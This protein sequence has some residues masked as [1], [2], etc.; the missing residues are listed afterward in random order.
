MNLRRVEWSVE[1]RERS[2]KNSIVKTVIVAVAC[3]LVS[4]LGHAQVTVKV[5]NVECLPIGENAVVWAEVD[6]NLPDSTVHL[7]FRRLHDMVEDFYYVQMV[8]AGQGRY[9][10]VMP[11]AEDRTLDRHE[12]EEE[13]DA[14]WAAWW[15][16]KEVRDDRDP[17]QDLD[18]ELIRERASQGRHVT[19]HWLE[20]MDDRTFEDWLE[21]LENEPAEYFVAVHDAQGKKIARS[22]TR[23][24]E[25]TNECEV[26]LTPQQQG[27]AQ[28]LV[29]GETAYWQEN[30]G[31]F[32]WMCDGVVTRIDPVRIKRA[33]A[34]CRTCF[35]CEPLFPVKP[36]KTEGIVTE[37]PAYRVSP[38]K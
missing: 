14:Q 8:P 3:L 38:N 21:T 28:N 12:L 25:V 9:W 16:A 7:N 29:V 4:V 23:V 27:E 22:R 11:K 19:R 1:S 37:K 5:D 26:V 32:H 34:I 10:G 13:V 36:I 6:G 2:M 15:R 35:P 17:N 18:Q 31:V 24:T 33:D 20:E 30:E